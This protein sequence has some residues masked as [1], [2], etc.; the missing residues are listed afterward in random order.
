MDYCA[1]CRR[2]L[3]LQFNCPGCGTPAWELHKY[4]EAVDETA[5]PPEPAGHVVGGAAGEADVTAAVEES[6][7]EATGA[8]DTRRGGDVRSPGGRRAGLRTPRT[9]PAAPRA[10]AR[11]HGGRGPGRA[12]LIGGCLLGALGLGVAA[13]TAV[14]G[15]NDPTTPAAAAA[16]TAP[17]EEARSAP[18]PQREAASATPAGDE[19]SPSASATASEPPTSSPSPSPP[20]AEPADQASAE[21][22]QDARPPGAADPEPAPSRPAPTTTSAPPRPTPTP[23]PTCERV[24]WWCT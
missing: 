22:G 7:V 14:G 19:P 23:S 6:G 10:A 24:L 4:A 18:S 13:V 16:D 5:E 9:E 17:A 3:N 8:G 15:E 2:H 20:A 1:R 12:L 11:R 21:S